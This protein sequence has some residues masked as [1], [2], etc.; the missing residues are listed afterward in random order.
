[1][2]DLTELARAVADTLAANPDQKSIEID[3]PGLT[4]RDVDALIGAVYDA[5]AAAGVI[6]KG[7]KVDPM[8]HPLPS[9]AQYI[10]AYVRDG[11]LIVI[12]LELDD[13]VIVRRK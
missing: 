5:C 10:N 6:V 4:S 7:V 1:M 9:G 12:D 13:K 2:P 8:Q 3:T 11:R